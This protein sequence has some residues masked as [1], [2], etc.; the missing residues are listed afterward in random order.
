MK[1][2]VHIYYI[3]HKS[4]DRTNR[5]DKEEINLFKLETPTL[6]KIFCIC[7]IQCN[8]VYIILRESIIQ[9]SSSSSPQTVFV[10]FLK[11]LFDKKLFSQKSF[12]VYKN[13][14]K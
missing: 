4:Q 14:L 7:V 1:G 5:Q 6:G 10:I 8:F 9:I 2:S 11:A 3:S 12:H 13:P